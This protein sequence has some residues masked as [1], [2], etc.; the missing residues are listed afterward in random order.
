[1]AEE[2]VGMN[3]E[4]DSGDDDGSVPAVS[5]RERLDYQLRVLSGSI[6]GIMR[7]DGDEDGEDAPD[8]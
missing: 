5:Q 1:M 3:L 8:A 6:R 4:L 2:A 7:P